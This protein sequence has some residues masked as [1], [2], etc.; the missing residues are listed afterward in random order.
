MIPEYFAVVGALIASI[1]G[2]YYLYETITGKSKPNRVTWLLWGIFPMITFIAQRAQGVEGVSWIT[3]VSGFTPILIFAASFI[4]KKA[5]WKSK[6]MDYYLM[7][8]AIAGIIMWALT[9][10]PNI[11][12]AFALLADLLAA[13]PTIIKCYR[14]P[15]SESWIAYGVSTAGFLM[16]LLAVQTWN[17]QNGAFV[18]YLVAINLVMA[19]LSWRKPTKALHIEVE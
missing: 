14:H 4:N 10:N 5:F 12:I 18:V 6:P 17:F 15:E 19:V 8:A 1:G 13:I 7:I 2:F 16:G 3:F 11:A 9:D